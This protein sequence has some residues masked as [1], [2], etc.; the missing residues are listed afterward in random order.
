MTY[1]HHALQSALIVALLP[2]IVGKAIGSAESSL[3]AQ[4]LESIRGWMVRSP[5]PWPDNWQREYLDTIRSAIASHQDAPQY[6]LRLE[7]L[8]EGFQPYWD[9]LKKSKDRS[10][11]EVHRA[12]IRWYAEHLMAAELPCDEE[13]QKLRDQYKD[14]WSYAASSLL[15]QFPFLDPN[16]VHTAKADDL[17]ECYR[18]IEAPLLPIFLRAFSQAQVE[19]I[20]QCWHDLRYARAN[21]KPCGSHRAFIRLRRISIKKQLNL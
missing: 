1:N 17:G 10:L 15:T 3:A 12:Q 9:A 19:R 16:I 21:K 13:R 5:A 11:F 7:I 2:A 18:K 4:T 20:K 6:A 8:H 14:L